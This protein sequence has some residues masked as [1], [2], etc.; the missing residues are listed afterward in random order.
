[1]LIQLWR[2]IAVIGRSLGQGDGM[3]D[4]RN[5][6]TPCANHDH[7]VQPDLLRESHPDIDAVDR[8]ARHASSDDVA[9][10]LL[11]RP[12]L[13][14]GHEQRPKLIA[15]GSSL[16]ANRGSS[17]RSRSPSTSHNRRNWPSLPAVMIK[18]P[19]A[20]GSGSYGNRLGWLFPIRKGTT[21]P[22]TTALEWLTKPDSAEE[23]RFTSTCCP[24]PVSSRLWRAAS[25]PMAACRPAITSK[26]EMPAR[27]GGPSESPVR[28]IRPDIAWTIRSYPGRTAPFSVVPKPLIEA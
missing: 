1:M 13:K 21:P 2:W 7:G 20:Q 3:T 12:G 11:L 24:R 9:E 18:S 5:R 14:L 19:S 15:V 8:T 17:T 25:T 6:R 22:A 26:T 16:W 28:L 4:R 27:Y 23:S 10:P